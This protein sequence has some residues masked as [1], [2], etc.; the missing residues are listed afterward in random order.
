[1]RMQP[2]V[3]AACLIAALSTCTSPR[4]DS[5]DAAPE[6]EPAP[7]G[8][9]NPAAAVA[10]TEPGEL[11]D[12]VQDLDESLWIVHQDKQGRYW[13]GSDGNGVYRYDGRNILRYT[14]QHGLCNDHIRQILE[15]E[16][17]NLYFNTN[18]GISKFDG[19][20]IRTLTP[21]QSD[22][23]A[24]EWKLEP[25]DLW[26]KGH[27]GPLRY[28]GESLHRLAFPPHELEG[29]FRSM[30]PSVP[31]SPY[32]IYVVGKDTTG[33]IWF[34]TAAF[35]ACRF[36]GNSFTWVSGDELTELEVG[37]SF[38]VR[39]IVEDKDGKF[40]L[41]NTVY[42][43]DVFPADPTARAH[44]AAQ[45]KQEHGLDQ[46]GLR[47]EADYAYFVSGLRG[48]DDALWLATYG[49]GVWRYDGQNLTHYPVAM[50]NQVV[51][52]YSIYEDDAGVLWLGSTQSGAY[53][54]N[55]EAFE[56]FRP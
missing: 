35:G 22:T 39:G 20:S 27:N 44:G 41:S 49:A 43:Y 53:R 47:G 16:S 17:G 40:W 3:I 10:S 6:H 36:D 31:Y 30:F 23:S 34:G 46:A 55:G 48:R 33:S 11:G 9:A 28:D 13:F 54:F 29:K 38:G 37:P 50:G 32:A 19:S 26:F 21:K 56:R 52:L 4:Y 14:T 25:G 8:I 12:V 5:S 24:G 15:D 51:L 42:R 7:G 1:M 2:P 18:G 45:Y